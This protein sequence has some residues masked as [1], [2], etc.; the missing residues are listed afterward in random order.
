MML[1]ISRKSSKTDD[2]DDENDT[3]D[4]SHQL[5]KSNPLLSIMKGQQRRVKG[6]RMQQQRRRKRNNNQNNNKNS[7]SNVN[8]ELHGFVVVLLVV[9]LFVA[10]EVIFVDQLFLGAG[11][12]IANMELHVNSNS[13]NVFVS[14]MVE[15]SMNRYRFHPGRVEFERVIES[16]EGRMRGLRRQH[17]TEEK[18]NADET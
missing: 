14:D 6:N 4:S 2:D 5:V 18:D 7:M 11:G 15:A 9:A 12:R 1:P 8:K 16:A 3:T 10:I 17:R 13:T